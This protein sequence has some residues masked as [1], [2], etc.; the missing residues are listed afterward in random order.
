MTDDDKRAFVQAFN[1]LAIATRLAESDA[2]MQRVYFEGLRDL[3]VESVTAAAAA[4][5]KSAQFFPR[6]AEWRDAARLQAV[7]LLKAL[8]DGRERPWEDECGACD[9]TGWEPRICY[10]GTMN[11]CG[12]RK[13]LTERAEHRYMVPCSCRST[14]RTYQRHHLLKDRLERSA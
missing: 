12:R 3:S 6:V 1:V 14:N 8:P 5:S 10:P 4:L 2:T 9:D 11:N 13:C 7:A